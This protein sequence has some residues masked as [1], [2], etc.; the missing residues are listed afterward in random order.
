M[1][2]NPGNKQN[3][4]KANFVYCLAMGLVYF[5]FHIMIARFHIVEDWVQVYVSFWMDVKGTK[6]MEETTSYT[7]DSLCC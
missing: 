1:I 5:G 2:S 4:P 7:V 3:R 6:V